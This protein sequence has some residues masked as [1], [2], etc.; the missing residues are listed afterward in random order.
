MNQRTAI[1][2]SAASANNGPRRSRLSSGRS[3][4]TLSSVLVCA[5]LAA[6]GGGGGG[7]SDPG[8]QAAAAASPP[9]PPQSTLSGAITPVSSTATVTVQL[10]DSTQ[11]GKT[12]TL[13]ATPDAS[14]AFTISAPT[15]SLPKNSQVAVIV[16]APGYLPTTIVYS[17]DAAG[18]ATPV[19]ATNALGT[20]AVT[21]PITLAQGAQGTFSF[22]GLDALY[23]LGDGNTSDTANS[24]LQLPAPPNTSPVI[25]KASQ[26]MA[27]ADPGKNQLRVSLLARGLEVTSCPGAKATLR[28]FDA[29]NVELAPL[30]QPM[31]DS[32]ATGEFGTQTLTFTIDSAALIGGWIQ[33]EVQTGQC[34]V[35]NYDDMEFVGTTGT[36]E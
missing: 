31:V 23:R 12:V 15:A 32:P 24:K 28:S 19:S 35:V 13:S 36:L 26:R 5:M 9:T 22:T 3:G 7:G 4:A 8:N 11:A 1:H 30:V 18:G 2:A 16:S 33:L 29:T 34:T 20:Q 10:L 27:F 25:S 21:G 14:G 6:C 17:T